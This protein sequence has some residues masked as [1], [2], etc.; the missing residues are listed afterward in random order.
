MEQNNIWKQLH[1][2]DHKL[3]PKKV[4]ENFS[5]AYKGKTQRKKNDLEPPS[6]LIRLKR[7]LSLLKLAHDSKK[8]SINP[9]FQCKKS[10]SPTKK[11]K[12]HCNKQS[13]F[14]KI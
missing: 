13:N 3:N 14:Y 11:F 9:A 4:S 7:N 6:H 12:I 2:K 1:L 10:P 8:E 5:L